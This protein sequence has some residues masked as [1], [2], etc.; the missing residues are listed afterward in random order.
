MRMKPLTNRK[1]DGIL[2]L[3]WASPDLKH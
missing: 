2:S 1:W 3:V